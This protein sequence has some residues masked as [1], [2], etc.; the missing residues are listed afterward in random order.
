[1]TAST[2][3]WTSAPIPFLK[4]TLI[5][6]GDLSAAAGTDRTGYKLCVGSPGCG[7]WNGNSPY[8]VGFARSRRL[9]L[10]GSWYE[11]SL[12]IVSLSTYMTSF[13]SMRP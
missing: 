6:L 12:E 7:I 5:V 4:E 11:V 2:P 10:E 3:Y 8:S 9:R 1:M 13:Q